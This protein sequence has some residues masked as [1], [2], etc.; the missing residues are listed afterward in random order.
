METIPG[1]PVS[2][3]FVKVISTESPSSISMEGPGIVGPEEYF[4]VILFKNSPVFA[5]KRRCRSN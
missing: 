5:L 2:L 4:F 1:A 3:G